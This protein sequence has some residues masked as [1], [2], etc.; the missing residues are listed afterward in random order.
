MS[1]TP[2]MS[3][4]APP[5]EHR[6][7]PSATFLQA[8]VC[9]VVLIGAALVAHRMDLLI[10]GTPFAVITAWSLATRPTGSPR[11][12]DPEV[13]SRGPLEGSA[14]RWTWTF[15]EVDGAEVAVTTFDH[16]PW[17]RT[18]PPGGST[19]VLPDSP[20][21]DVTVHWQP[22]RWGPREIFPARTHLLSAWGSFCAGPY[23]TPGR[24]LAVRPAPQ[25]FGGKAALPH[26]IGLIGQNRSRRIGDGSE[27]AEIREFRTGDRLRRI[28]W[29]IT[30]RTGRLHVR[31]SYAEQD[32][33]VLVL[34][35]AS[36]DFGRSRPDAGLE[37]SL[38]LGVRATLAL[39]GHFLTRGERVGVR[40]MGTA[41]NERIHAASG[42]AQYQRI[43]DILTTVESVGVRSLPRSGL[44]LHASFGALVL[45]VS[46]LV[47][48]EMLTIAAD[49]AR[50]GRPLVVIDCLPEAVDTGFG[51]DPL[52][53]L[54]LRL[55]LVERAQEIRRLQTHG[56]PVVPWRGPGS[57]DPVL[58]QLSRRP[59]RVITR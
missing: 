28:S 51:D 34:L 8:T 11:A 30:A 2:D 47:N 36:A 25:P 23:D 6:W 19:M 46:P 31:T 26:P 58:R 59:P 21:L 44:H 32:T 9:A 35:D 40:A 16:D 15:G 45:L 1:A 12:S 10:I 39:A 5:G 37:S 54:A 29:P 14:Q 50:R 7:T 49:I 17:V 41:R 20:R 13:T 18:D 43:C 53:D 27:F 55:R 24:R 52:A 22:T 56:A 57:L 3:A 42:A 38:D 4:T 33:E 48:G